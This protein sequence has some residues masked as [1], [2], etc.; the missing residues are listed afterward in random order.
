MR[1]PPEEVA[2]LLEDVAR[3]RGIGERIGA[4]SRRFLGRPYVT[5]PLVGAPSEPEQLVTRLDAFD[6]VTFVESV[7]ALASARAPAEF[8]RELVQ[9][10]Y[11]RGRVEWLHRNHYTSDWFERN[12]E[13]GRLAPVLGDQWVGVP[14]RLSVLAG[15][16]VRDRTVYWLP[17]ERL[18]ALDRAGCTGD[19][20]G[21]G[22]TRSDLDTSHVGL[23]VR[24]EAG[25][26]V[27]HASRSAGMVVEATLSEYLA[28]NEPPGL[29]VARPVDRGEVT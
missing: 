14:R 12:V 29:L 13:A 26:H 17:F 8:E 6:C 1:A 27:R 18:D 24:G 15:Y 16:P 19:V 5:E 20:V 7:L 2:S 11:H 22:S 25:L 28:R 21:F 3:V 10:R 23:L 9:I 4:I